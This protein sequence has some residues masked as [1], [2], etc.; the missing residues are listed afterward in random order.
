MRDSQGGGESD[1]A[2]GVRR[3]CM[4]N[5]ICTNVSLPQRGGAIFARLSERRADITKQL[6][7]G[8]RPS[9]RLQSSAEKL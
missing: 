9:G 1:P 7:R 8:A 2:E 6:P 4:K 3:R 5:Y